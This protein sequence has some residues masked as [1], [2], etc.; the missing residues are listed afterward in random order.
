MMHN[1][2]APGDN[3]PAL[4]EPAGAV[5]IGDDADVPPNPRA[6]HLGYAAEDPRVSATLGG[7]PIMHDGDTETAITVHSGFITDLREWR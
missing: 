4:P 7:V 6:E 5:D 1:W 3:P 2:R